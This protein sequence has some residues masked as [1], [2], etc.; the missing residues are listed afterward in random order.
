VDHPDVVFP[1]RAEKEAAVVEEIAAMHRAG[2]PVLVGTASVA[3]SERL[4]RMVA[5]AGIPH[6]VLNARDDARE[7]RIVAR[8]GALGAVTISTNMAG[9]GTDIPLGGP[10]VVALGGLHVIGTN[11]HESRRIDH[12]LRGRAG[13]QG[14]PGSSR[15]LISLEDEL[16][17]R[18]GVAGLL[19]QRSIAGAVE[20]VQ[21]IV[22]EENL[23]IRQTLRKYEFLIEG[24]RRDLHGRR[25]KLLLGGA[26]PAQLAAIDELWADHL[27]AVAEL[28]EGGC[29]IALGGKDPFPE[30]LNGVCR[31]F[32]DLLAHLDVHAAAPESWPVERGATWTYLINDQPF[33]S[34]TDRLCAGIR[35]RIRELWTGV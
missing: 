35:R 13:R 20:T 21:R 18:Y 17:A 9:R 25:Q 7:A 23:E 5:E 27:A 2:R 34:L 15:F 16:L 22:E 8:A 29:W 28:R 24:Q 3:E 33:G 4:S 19:P 6:E 26:P 1:T 30:F 12:Q 10:E 14:D 32:D 31:L 11:R